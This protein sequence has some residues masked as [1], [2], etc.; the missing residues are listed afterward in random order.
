MFKFE[1]CVKYA[2]EMTD[3]V[4]HSTLIELSWQICSTCHWASYDKKT[5]AQQVIPIALGYWTALL[6]CPANKTRG[7][8]KVKLGTL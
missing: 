4:I 2:N 5:L 7:V 1:K 6:L 3:D 8:V